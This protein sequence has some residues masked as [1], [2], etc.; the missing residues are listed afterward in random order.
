[1]TEMPDGISHPRR[2]AGLNGHLP[3]LNFAVARKAGA[4]S[5]GAAGHG[6]GI[7]PRSITSSQDS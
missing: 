2:R 1:M 6:D 7:G 4:R 5:G 3:V